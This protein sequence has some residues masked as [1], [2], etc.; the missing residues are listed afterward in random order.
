MISILSLS[1][2]QVHVGNAV[3]LWN[4]FR[5]LMEEWLGK[6]TRKTGRSEHRSRRKA[7]R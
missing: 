2:K 3:R 1:K 7:G 6:D 5:R 4:T